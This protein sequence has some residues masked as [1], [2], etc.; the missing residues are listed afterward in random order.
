MPGLTRTVPRHV[1][2][3]VGI[4][5]LAA[6]LR[7]YQIGANPLWFD[8]FATLLTTTG[9]GYRSP[10]LPRNVVIGHPIDPASLADAR[11]IWRVWT[12]LDRD[13][14]PPLYYLL[15]RI[16]RELFGSSAA[17]VRLLG[18]V[19]SVLGVGLVFALGRDL[20]GTA[21]GAWAGLILGLILGYLRARMG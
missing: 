3:L 8:E 14:H 2:L 6:A 15:L 9:W 16:W 7:I 19:F 10:D 13:P 1:L 4:L 18:T 11:P 5:V 12:A 21:V 17:V 20:G